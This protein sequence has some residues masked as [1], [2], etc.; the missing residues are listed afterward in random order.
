MKVIQGLDEIYK[1]N[2][3]IVSVVRI[4]SSYQYLSE[5]N[6]NLPNNCNTF[7]SWWFLTLFYYHKIQA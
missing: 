5:W 4:I 2:T 6:F 1:K 7:L 3:S